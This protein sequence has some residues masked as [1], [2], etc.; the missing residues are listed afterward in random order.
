MNDQ[1]ARVP[2]RDLIIQSYAV[3]SLLQDRAP[4][5]RRA[6]LLSLL[7][8]IR[9]QLIHSLG[10]GIDLGDATDAIVEYFQQMEGTSLGIASAR[11]LRRRTS[12]E[13]ISDI[14]AKST[15]SPRP[16]EPGRPLPPGHW[17]AVDDVS[18]EVPLLLRHEGAY[19]PAPLPADVALP[20]AT[21]RVLAET[22]HVLGRLDQAVHRLPDRQVFSL[23]QC[24]R[25][26]RDDKNPAS[27]IL[28][29]IDDRSAMPQPVGGFVTAAEYGAKRAASGA[30]VDAELMAEINAI[31]TGRHGLRT[32]Q[33]WLSPGAAEHA[34][35]LTATGSHL[36][37]ML[38]Q[39]S[40]WTRSESSL[41]RLAKIA[42]AHHQLEVLQPF[43][44]ANGH[45]A[46][47]YTALE[48]I[49]TGLLADHL[50]P[51]SDWYDD[52]RAE[53]H[54]R[55]R[56]LVSG[57]P[58]HRWVE[59]FANGV[60]DTALAQLRLI[61]ELERLRTDLLRHVPASPAV[62][63]VV[64]GLV[65]GPA[66]TH[67]M[68]ETRYGLSSRTS[69]QIIRHLVQH[70]VLT[71]FPRR[72]TQKIFVCYLALDLLTFGYTGGKP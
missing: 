59:F 67:R 3:L 27:L 40:T 63:R 20:A 4:L 7:R 2:D 37:A 58:V 44:T 34:Y 16:R 64:S 60:R 15:E 29:L 54:R 61:E 70:R 65:T 56:D 32:H 36:V 22:E 30:P 10:T 45:V 23:V 72:H 47:L 31:L 57:G 14:I 71:V 5:P 11:T 69:A 13:V 51:L 66:V 25:D 26:A 38:E 33:G 21:Y 6:E 18:E 55:I 68:L 53:Y 43:P 49:G 12:P 35:L 42:L 19:V 8:P 1:R 39:W 24:I 28:P 17:V 52:H 46:R 48:M 50:L 62:A 41:P 9:D